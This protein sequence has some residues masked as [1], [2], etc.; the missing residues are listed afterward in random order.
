MLTLVN[1]DAG[2]CE[3]MAFEIYYTSTIGIALIIAEILFWLFVGYG[4]LK[5]KKNKKNTWKSP[6]NT[7][8]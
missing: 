6:Y 3:N 2:R 4:V 1:Y 7:Q 5:Y 8:K